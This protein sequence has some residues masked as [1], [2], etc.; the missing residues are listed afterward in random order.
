MNSRERV[1]TAL[2]HKQPDRVATDLSG[3][4][5]S[6]MS[7]IA[8]SKLRKYL[9]FEERPIRIYDMVQQLAIVD[10]DMLDYFNID[11]IEM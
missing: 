4:R 2:N 10:D 1:L 7:A 6:G 5:S 8:Y 9:G 11:V 3:H